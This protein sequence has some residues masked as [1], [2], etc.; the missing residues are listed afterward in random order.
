MP[1]FRTLPLVLLVACAFVGCNPRVPR[2]CV[3]FDQISFVENAPAT[4]LDV[5]E[6]VPVDA[7]GAIDIELLD[8]FLVVST[9]GRERLLH[10]Y[11]EEDYLNAGE[12]FR[13][14]NGP[15]EVTSLITLTNMSVF[16]E[17]GHTV[18]GLYDNDHFYAVNLSASL[19]AGQVMC[20]WS[21]EVPA[22]LKTMRYVNR[23][24]FLCRRWIGESRMQRFLYSSGEELPL[25]VTEP[26]DQSVSPGPEQMNFNILNS[27]L[28][29]DVSRQRVVEAST[30]MNTIHIYD[31]DG[32][33]RR[34]LCLGNR[35]TD[36][37][38]IEHLSFWE[39]PQ[40]F[41]DLRVSS[42]GFSCLFQH[43]DV[44]AFDW[45]GNLLSRWTLPEEVDCFAINPTADYLYT[46]S[47]EK[48][49]IRRYRIPYVD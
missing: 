34:T 21:E 16:S 13:L 14:G 22:S 42:D 1:V 8:S 49:E 36:I 10:F 40:C 18:I 20:D 7:I 11:R 19:S 35:I 17:D 37:D 6:I 41:V 39:I 47:N 24:E 15:Y 44:L 2:H 33:F 29:Y 38:K 48:E 45:E 30:R 28:G 31:L 3:A 46:L 9:E 32:P 4:S 25:V 43:R 5:G 23:G 12:L 27:L 26:L